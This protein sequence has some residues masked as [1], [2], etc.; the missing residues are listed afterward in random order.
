MRRAAAALLLATLL[1]TAVA[2]CGPESSV[3]GS[4]TETTASIETT[5]PADDAATDIPP[6]ATSGG[7]GLNASGV[8]TELNAMEKELDSLDMPSDADFSN[9]EG[10]LY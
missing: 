4:A 6:S 1:G 8:D 7:S 9:A 10:A 2:G 3:T 5:Q